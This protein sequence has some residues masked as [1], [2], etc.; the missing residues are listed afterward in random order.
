MFFFPAGSTS[1]ATRWFCLTGIVAVT[2][3]AGWMMFPRVLAPPHWLSSWTLQGDP[4]RKGLLLAC[5]AVYAL[6]LT[7]TLF[8]FLQRKFIWT[9]ALTVTGLMVFV[10]FS[11]A[12][13]GGAN[14]HP[15]GAVEAV[16]LLL[17]LAG[18][19]LN[20][21]AEYDRLRFKSQPAN[22]GRL[23]TRGWFA[24]VRHP[25]YLGDSILF[26]GLALVT[27]RPAMLVIPLI[28]TLNFVLILIP[29][30]EAYLKANYGQAFIDYA[31][32]TRKFIPRIY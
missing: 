15:V 5:L 4:L 18:S 20:T 3:W 2:L 25:N 21:R 26:S 7:L 1:A 10:I 29:R 16:G 28:M 9:E 27:G 12:R 22:H 30:K 11:F 32:G 24:L 17:Y 6:R 23:Y 31:A 13:Q 19:Y 14:I 8:V